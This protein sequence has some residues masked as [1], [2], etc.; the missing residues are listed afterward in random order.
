MNA[1]IRSAGFLR[2]V[3]NYGLDEI[4]REKVS[5]SAQFTW[6]H[7]QTNF[8][9]LYFSFSFALSLFSCSPLALMPYLL[10]LMNNCNIPLLAMLISNLSTAPFATQRGRCEGGELP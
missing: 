2:V 7:A 8:L 6:S 4:Y 3:I 5:P 1:F 10:C 9:H